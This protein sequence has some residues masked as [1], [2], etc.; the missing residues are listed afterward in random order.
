MTRRKLLRKAVRIAGYVGV[1]L[2]ALAVV[3]AIGAPIYFR[4]ERFGQLVEVSLPETRGHVHVGGGYWSWGATI[5]N[6]GIIRPGYYIVLPPK[7]HPF[8]RGSG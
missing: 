7:P 2:V 4:G 1:G 8:G 3:I 6:S 5:P